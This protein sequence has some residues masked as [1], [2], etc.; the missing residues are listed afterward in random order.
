MDFVLIEFLERNIMINLNNVITK[1]LND[2]HGNMHDT[3]KEA[4][5]I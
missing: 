4:S 5:D 2:I 1:L 3:Q